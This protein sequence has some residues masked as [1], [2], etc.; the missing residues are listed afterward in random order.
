[1]AAHCVVISSSRRREMGWQPTTLRFLSIISCALL[2]CEA[3]ASTPPLEASLVDSFYGTWETMGNIADGDKSVVGQ[4]DPDGLAFYLGDQNCRLTFRSTD[5]ASAELRPQ[6]FGGQQLCF[7]LGKKLDIL[8]G[9]ATAKI[10]QITR[11][12]CDQ[13]SSNRLK[14]SL[15]TVQGNLEYSGSGRFDWDYSC[16]D[17]KGK[18]CVLQ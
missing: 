3:P 12:W 2:A 16:P 18:Q 1:M 15:K 11:S 8:S 4:K 6:P 10:S 7:L 14:L 17:C 13:K 5:V 9:T